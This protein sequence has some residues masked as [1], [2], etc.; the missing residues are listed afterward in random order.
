LEEFNGEFIV[1]HKTGV[2][3]RYAWDGQL[4][5]RIVTDGKLV[6]MGVVCSG[7]NQ[8]LVVNSGELLTIYDRNWKVHQR[9][10]ILNTG[11]RV[12]PG[13]NRLLLFVPE[14]GVACVAVKD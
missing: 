2:L 10:K 6:N 13:T 3:D 11:M 4:K 8:Y 5:L 7:S 12:V 1:G 14:E 9:L